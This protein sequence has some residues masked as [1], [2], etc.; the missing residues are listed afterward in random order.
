MLH[1]FHMNYRCK[2]TFQI[3]PKTFRKMDLIFNTFSFQLEFN[4]NFI[5]Y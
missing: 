5:N 3:N 4:F 2:K 1:M